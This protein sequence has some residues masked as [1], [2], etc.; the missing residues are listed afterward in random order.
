[1]F[2]V[3]NP[4][5]LVLL[6][7]QPVSLLLEPKLLHFCPLTTIPTPRAEFKSHRPL[8]CPSP[9]SLSSIPAHCCL[10]TPTLP[11]Q[12]EGSPK[13]Q[14]RTSILPLPWFPKYLLHVQPPPDFHLHLNHPHKKVPSLGFL[15]HFSGGCVRCWVTC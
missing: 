2:R 14:L 1:M 13:P 5:Q 11:V 15:F 4:C 3:S 10:R 9:A 8:L 12:Q 6:Q 7:V